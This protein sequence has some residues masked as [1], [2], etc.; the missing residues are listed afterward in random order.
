MFQS[1]FPFAQTPADALLQQLGGMRQSQGIPFVPVRQ[2]L[3]VAP[4]VSGGG[5]FFPPLPPRPDST[6][7]FTQTTVATVWTIN[8]N[9][10]Q[11]P[12]V[13]T[14]D[15]NGNVIIG[16]VQYVSSNQITV[17]FSQPVSGVAYLNV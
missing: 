5:Y 16:Q 3:P 9:L 11:F 2:S 17:T 15:P 8:H 1:M 6:Y 7:V 14:T 13:T 4:I 10:G 12:S